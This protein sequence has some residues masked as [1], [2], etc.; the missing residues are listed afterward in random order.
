MASQGL[1]DAPAFEIP[2][3][4]DQ[5]IDRSFLYE[6]YTTKGG[7]AKYPYL[8]NAPDFMHTLYSICAL[9][10]SQQS[11]GYKE[12]VPTLDPEMPPIKPLNLNH[13]NHVLAI[14]QRDFDLFL[15]NT[16]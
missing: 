5:E 10:L 6:C 9:S 2:D 4:P 8:K 11:L 12:E 15:N 16:I 1:R 13:L 14:P 7:F 3:F